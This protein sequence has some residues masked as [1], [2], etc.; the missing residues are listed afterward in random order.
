MATTDVAQRLVTR[1]RK[2]PPGR[3]TALVRRA[4]AIALFLAATVLAVMPGS[5]RGEPGEPTVVT[6]RDLPPGSV[7]HAADVRLVQLPVSARP[8]G[9]LTSTAAVPGRLLIGPAREGEPLTDVRL[10]DASTGS[11]SAGDPGRSTVPVR[12]ADPDVAALLRPGA[13]VDVVAAGSAGIDDHAADQGATVLAS[14]ATVITVT[15][16][17]PASRHGPGTVDRGALVLLEL[18]SGTAARVAAA[19]LERPVA[20]TLR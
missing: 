16:P 3:L 11:L 1:L 18:P 9:T 14:M 20:V 5:A 6:T 17:D 10:A 4:L 12:L 8:A 19:S 13:R 15:T 2:V 7:L